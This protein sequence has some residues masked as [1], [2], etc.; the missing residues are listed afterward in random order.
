MKTRMI[1]LA[2]ILGVILSILIPFAIPPVVLAQT[3]CRNALGVVI[4]CPEEQNK[5]KTATPPRPTRT[6]TPTSTLTPSVTP[7]ASL[8]P[9]AVLP[10]PIIPGGD[11]PPQP[12]G[13]PGGFGWLFGLLVPAVLVLLGWFFLQQNRKGGSPGS[14]QGFDT[15]MK[16][17]ERSGF[18]T[19]MRPGSAQ[20]FDTEMQPGED[21]GTTLNNNEDGGTMLNNNDGGAS[22]TNN[23]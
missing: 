5:K 21:G 3:V 14:E 7:V 20:G 6:P 17:G 18:D 1:V 13:F 4:P 19:D 23:E 11:E 15:D 10:L 8:T 9:T 12:S 16:P 22:M 2:I